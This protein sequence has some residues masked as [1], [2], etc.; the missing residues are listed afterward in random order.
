M[1]LRFPSS[2]LTDATAEATIAAYAQDLEPFP[3]WAIDQAI[4]TAIE[5]G[6][7]FAPSSPELRKACDRAVAASR[8]E[9][10]EIK[11]VLNAAVFRE[12]SAA[13]RARGLAMFREVIADLELNEPF[14]N[15]AKRPLSS[16]NRPEAESAL[17]R[18]RADPTP[19]PKLSDAARKSM[20]L[21]PRDANADA[22]AAA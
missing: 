7:A 10:A 8:V 1:F 19:C 22:N 9:A 6:G 12:P 4:I 13:E 2:R 5:K 17:E 20:G 14:G 11:A 16:I 18:L 15:V 21:P 3:V